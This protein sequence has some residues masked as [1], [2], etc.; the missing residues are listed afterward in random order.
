MEVRDILALI[1]T[2]KF[3]KKVF[4]EEAGSLWQRAFEER[5]G[6]FFPITKTGED[7]RIRF[8]K[9]KPWSSQ[10]L[11]LKEELE[12]HRSGVTALLLREGTLFSASH[13]T[14]IKVH[15]VLEGSTELERTLTGHN[16]TIW[17]LVAD[18]NYLYSGSNDCTVRVWNRNTYT[19]E[20]TLNVGSKVF[21]LRLLGPLLFC[22][23]A[24]GVLH[25]WNTRNHFEHVEKVISA[26]ALNG[27]SFSSDK[28]TLFVASE[29][30]ISSIDV[31]TLTVTQTLQCHSPASS[32]A[33][34]GN[35]LFCGSTGDIQ[36]WDT[37]TSSPVANWAAHR[38]PIWQLVL[39]GGNLVSGSFDHQLKIWDI[40]R[41]GVQLE[42]PELK[43]R[44]H[45]GWIHALAADERNLYSGAADKMLKRWSIV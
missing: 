10:L 28:Q 11:A 33:V 23:G 16:Y 35:S 6:P 15:K 17:S 31:E 21:N 39:A 43:S 2:S 3:F 9:T 42:S 4:T 27:I 41:A 25:I 1:L 7:W 12:V 24:A 26:R 37:R 40:R 32:L 38:W 8:L 20:E 44:G 19:T 5:W 45:R 30:C 14:T 18:D 36:L 13:D 29:Q 22:T 34:Y